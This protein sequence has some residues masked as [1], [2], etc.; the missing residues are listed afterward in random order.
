M[1][2][3][4]LT[5]HATFVADDTASSLSVQPTCSTAATIDATHHLTSPPGAYAI[6][7]T[8]AVDP[9]YVV[10]YKEGTLTVTPPLLSITV[11]ASGP[12]GSSPRLTSLS[13]AN[14]AIH[15]DP[16]GQAGHVTGS[17]TCT[18]DATA[19]SSVSGRPYTISNCGGLSDAGFTIV[20]DYA[21]SA[22]TVTLAPVHIVYTGPMSI[23]QTQNV[24][25][26]ATLTS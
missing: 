8:G 2:L 15:Y 14:R 9:D 21:H 10:T 12:Y 4:T 19:S 5:W 18:T 6:T 11:T 3:P 23:R 13:P 16:S 24:T 1:I 17:L 25:L 22:Y 20:Y 7:C 26:S